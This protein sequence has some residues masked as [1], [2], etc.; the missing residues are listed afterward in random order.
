[1]EKG[2]P[3]VF[4]YTMGGISAY[5]DVNDRPETLSLTE[6]DDLYR[7]LLEALKTI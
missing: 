2:V 4:I 5:Y 3:A 6:F 7:L 1:V